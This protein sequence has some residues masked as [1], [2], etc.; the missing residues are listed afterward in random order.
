[1]FPEVAAGV[2][3]DLEFG[4][5]VEGECCIEERT[6]GQSLVIG[7]AIAHRPA[8]WVVVTGEQHP[9]T[10]HQR[11]AS[12]GHRKAGLT[13]AGSAGD[14]DSSVGIEPFQHPHVLTADLF[15]PCSGQAGAGLGVPPERGVRSQHFDDR[16]EALGSDWLVAPSVRHQ[17]GH[18]FLRLVERVAGEDLGPV[19]IFGERADNVE[20]VGERDGV[21]DVQMFEAGHQQA[22]AVTQRVGV[23]LCL[24][25]R[26]RAHRRP[27]A[28]PHALKDLG[29]MALHFHDGNTFA[30]VGEHDVH[31]PIPVARKADIGDDQP[32]IG[33]PV[34]ERFDHHSFLVIGQ[35]RQRKVLR[36]QDAH[37]VILHQ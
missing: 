22:Q 8:E 5:P 30:F 9:F 23:A 31:L 17:R 12:P 14:H 6:N 37:R 28:R 27:V 16:L 25:E 32:A 18:R 2:G 10:A 15:Q 7:H 29:P 36:N 26:W 20:R 24:V 35:L 4:H 13:G 3:G 19:H 21:L 33:E 1:M 11:T 34:A